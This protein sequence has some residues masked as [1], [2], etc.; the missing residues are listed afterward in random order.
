MEE[1]RVNK[2]RQ[3]RNSLNFKKGENLPSYTNHQISKKNADDVLNE[4]KESTSSISTLS[5]SY[6]HI[7]EATKD[8][9]DELL[10]DK[11]R[12]YKNRIKIG[13]IIAGCVILLAAIIVSAIFIFK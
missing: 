4:K 3:Y 9:E 2:Y 10:F 5:I 11:K 1:T 12:R 13:L 7:F 8:K 6:Q